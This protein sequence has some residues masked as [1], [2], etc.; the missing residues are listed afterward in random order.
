MR[1][2]RLCFGVTFSLSLLYIA[3]SLVPLRSF[4][5]AVS[6]ASACAGSAV[7]E[8]RGFLMLLSLAISSP[9][10][11]T[12]PRER[13]RAKCS[14]LLRSLPRRCTALSPLPTLRARLFACVLG[15]LAT[16]SDF[17]LVRCAL[18]LLSLFLES[19]PSR[20]PSNTTILLSTDH[21]CQCALA[22]GACLP[23]RSWSALAPFSSCAPLT[24]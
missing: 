23:H 14:Y 8:L 24:S 22:S 3:S 7:A 12:W 6:H 17:F 15:S 10:H 11:Q 1:R 18:I 5:L 21:A 19:P 2:A 16:R 4:L 13:E 9:F 20:P